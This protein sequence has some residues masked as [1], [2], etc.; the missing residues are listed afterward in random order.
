M[1]IY[2][3]NT[4]EIPSFFNIKKPGQVKG[5]RKVSGLDREKLRHQFNV[6]ASNK[7]L[8]LPIIYYGTI[9]HMLQ[10]H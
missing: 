4:S 5:L 6:K 7:W 2:S 10:N 1:T 8:F 3:E 9:I